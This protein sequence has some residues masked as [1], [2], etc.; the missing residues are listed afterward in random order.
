[1][2]LGWMSSI[3]ANEKV[4]KRMI[5]RVRDFNVK[6]LWVECESFENVIKKYNK[7]KR[8]MKTGTLLVEHKE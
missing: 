4:Y 2:F 3:Y 1:M 5:E 7:G 8:D 6:N